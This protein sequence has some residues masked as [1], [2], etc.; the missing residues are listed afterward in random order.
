MTP[1]SAVDKITLTFTAAQ[2]AAA[3][4]VLADLRGTRAADDPD[5]LYV[6]Y[7][8]DHAAHE[9]DTRVAQPCLRCGRDVFLDGAGDWTHAAADGGTSRGC[10]AA[11]FTSETGWDESLSQSWKAKGRD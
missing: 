3:N 7:A 9:I 4:A 1:V 5:L 6:I 11:S 2:V 8:F 10:Y